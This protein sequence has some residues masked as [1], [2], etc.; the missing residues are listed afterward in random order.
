MT[1]TAIDL[2]ALAIMATALLAAAWSDLRH[3]LIPNRYPAAIAAAYLIPAVNQPA[4]QSLW[5]L[6][7][8]LLFFGAGA[9]LFAARAMGGGDVKLMAAVAIWAGPALALPFVEVIAFSGAALA[10][11][12]L[13]PARRLLPDAPGVL[14]GA[15]SLRQRLKEPVPYGI[16]ITAGGLYLAVLRVLV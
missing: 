6:G 3:Y 10:L 12:W 8:G 7:I 13:S 16:A 9:A 11:V 14:A 5:A 1:A 15:D 4:S 2:L